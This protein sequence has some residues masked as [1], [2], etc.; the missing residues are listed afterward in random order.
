MAEPVRRKKNI[1]DGG[2]GVHKRGEGLGTG[3]VGSS[4]GYSGKTTG[5]GGGSTGGNRSGGGRSPLSIIVIIAILLLGGGG[6]LGGL[7]GGLGD[8]GDDYTQT[9]QETTVTS[10]TNT[11]SDGAV[12]VGSTSS[13]SQSS[14]DTGSSMG[15]LLG[16]LLGG[17]SG[18]YG[19][20]SSEWSETP[21][22]G[23]LDETT[24]DGIRD[25]R[26]VIK[27]DGTDTTT[28]MVY[29]CGTD[30]ESRSAMATKDLQEMMAADLSDN[31]NI[32]V[33]T[34]GCK[35]WQNNVISSK[36]NQIYK[37]EKGGLKR[38]KDGLGSVAMTNPDT[39]SGFI[40]W[41]S[42]N[43]PADRY[44]L[45]FWDHGGGSLSGYGYDE[46]F[47]MSGSMGLS[48]INKAL[49]D[50][51]VT[52]DFIGFDACLMAT[53][54]T[55]MVVSNYAD[56][57]IASEETEPGVG[58]YYTEWL[59]TYSKNPSLD[60]LHI[61]KSIIDSYTAEC[62]RTCRGQKTTLSLVDLAELEKTV[63]DELKDFANSTSELIS[64]KEYK[65]VS[66]ARSQAREFAASSKIDQVD[67]IHL[68]SNMGSQEGKEL[69]DALKSCV[70][71]NKT[72]STMTNA[73]GLSIYFPYKKTSK[74]DSMVNTYEAI[75][76]DDSY[77]D[78]I[79]KFASLEVAGQVAAGGTS[80]P[81]GS[82]FGD[83]TGSSAS[84]ADVLMQLF[85]TMLSSGVTGISGLDASN[86]EFFGKGL[87][88]E[89]A[90]EYIA[91]NQFDA[92]KLF[93]TQN[94][95]GEDV[96][97]MPQD[98]WD[99]IQ[100]LDINMF[101]DDGTGYVDLGLDNS[102][103]LDEDGNPVAPSD[104]TWL[105][106]DGQ[107]VHYQRIDTQGD[108]SNYAIMG[109]VPVMLNEV[110]ADLILIFDSEN[111]DGYVAGATFDYVE[112]E[113][114]TVAKNLTELNEGDTIDFL[115]DFY[116]YDQQYEDTYFLGETMTVDKPMS[117]MHIANVS[118]GDGNVLVTFKFTD[119]YGQEYWTSAM[120]Y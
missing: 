90:A 70:K 49:K 117:E 55:A 97:Q 110:R 17:G 25:R 76:M 12:S 2:S 37:V 3:P 93:W 58:W 59:N 51:G 48:G 15:S 75:G 71:Y 60:T 35:Q 36:T 74:V 61:G 105:S 10:T 26:T 13:D 87:D 14:I 19:S 78:C 39:L 21:N 80:S 65:T 40:K 91:E 100:D 92:E 86:T 18:Y 62:E 47:A 46:K 53:V 104:R 38:L 31:I 4:D 120:E 84:S 34:G 85:G 22:T 54:E 52:Y 30:L 111:E 1:E 102:Y 107:V 112:G 42:E 33:Y 94:S 106:I 118:V 113:T 83:M 32:I 67:L 109:R 108:S 116:D 11:Q 69:A 114:E 7:L 81:A 99:L 95:E 5:G 57:M 82:L 96:I 119:I 50:G 79:Q 89:A 88:P 24:V 56:Y 23:S 43:Y 8:S 64:Q 20:A 63:P 6:G 9:Q 29:M 101:Y 27:G 16:T 73:Y 68:A 28:I 115:T 77:A 41:T 72:S 103:D 45:I 44:D 66:N 98:Q